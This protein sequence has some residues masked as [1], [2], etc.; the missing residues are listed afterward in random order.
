MLGGSWFPVSGDDLL[1]TLAKITPHYW[2]LEGLDQLAGATSWTV[3]GPYVLA[4]LVIAV[5]TG[6]PATIM[7]RR[8]LVP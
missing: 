6:V 3:I 1:G 7:L 8:R 4:L 2:F 5:A